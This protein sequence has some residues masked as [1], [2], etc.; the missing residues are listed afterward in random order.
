MGKKSKRKKRPVQLE[1]NKPEISQVI[2]DKYING[3]F[4]GIRLLPAVISLAAAAYFL[5]SSYKANGY[6]GFPL[7]DPWIHLNFAKNLVNYGSFS[8]FKNELVTSGSTSPIYTLLAA[9][10]FIF[11]KNEFLISYF[12][13]IS[14][15]AAVV[16]IVIKLFQK[17]APAAGESAGPLSLLAL[18]A[19]LLAALQPKLSLINVSGMETSMFIFFIAASLLAYL[20]N[21]M[22][23]LGVF[24]GLSLWCR[25][26]GLV[27]WAAV[28]CD[29]FIQEYLPGKRTPNK[30]N[31]QRDGNHKK[32]FTALSTAFIFLAAYFAFNYFLSGSILPNT[33]S[34][35]LEYYQHNDR[36]SFLENEVIKYFTQSEFSLFWIPFLIGA[37]GILKS[38]FK[39]ERNNLLVFLLFITGLIGIYYIKLPFAH[40]FGRYLMPA[41]PFYIVIAL[42]GVK[43]F[44]DFINSK[45]RNS[46]LL[47][48]LFIIYLIVSLGILIDNNF[49]ESDEYTFFCKYHNDRHVAAGKWLK[50]N[51]EKDAVVATHDIGA[52]AFY[53]ERKMID[54]AGLI[55]PE[56]IDEINKPSYTEYLNNYFNTHRVDYLVTLR[57]WFEVVND[58]PVF[59]PV[60]AAE[61]LEV[62]KYKP[63]VTHILPKTVSL[64]NS[65]AIQMLQ[66]GRP[67]DALAYLNRSLSLDSC[68][69][70]TYIFIGAAYEMLRDYLKA[71]QSFSRAVK[72]FPGYAEAY[73]GLA[74]VSFDQNKIEDSKKF[75][76]NCLRINPSYAPAVQMKKDLTPSANTAP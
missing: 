35:K 53:S 40:R 31:S 33:Y 76:D 45:F 6:F 24:L 55:T 48:F 10:L 32:I 61:F 64:L 36:A 22:I 2:Y 65:S 62:F 7:D 67:S 9:L 15:G 26:D 58:N 42:S 69:S 38:L 43:I 23:L 54:M 4:K 52:I 66:N 73:F 59:V 25:P 44:L 3:K 14:F 71:E 46:S 27:V 47:N 19:G 17:A 74:K 50:A 21:K 30:N 57:N 51:T 75:L 13:G 20:N 29:Y 56:L 18:S 34:A 39:K 16:Y 63:S 41:I 68:S 70:R 8:Y 28:I 11:F 37:F 12:I 1:I 60:N 49:K 5:F 72:L